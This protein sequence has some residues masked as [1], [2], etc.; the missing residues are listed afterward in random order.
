[1]WFYSFRKSINYIVYGFEILGK[2][3]KLF[4][5]ILSDSIFKKY[6]LDIN[7]VFS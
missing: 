4:Q 3:I 7:N 1:M 5:I 6:I 2:N